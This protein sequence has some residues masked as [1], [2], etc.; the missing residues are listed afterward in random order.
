[1]TERIR[2]ERFE[3]CSPEVLNKSA[4]KPHTHNDRVEA[5]K[6]HLED[7]DFFQS[8]YKDRS[9]IPFYHLY[10]WTTNV[11]MTLLYMIKFHFK[12]EMLIF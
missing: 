5:Y 9:L 8:C 12:W 1:M 2:L 10:L 3:L 11:C 6:I 4:Y 7:S